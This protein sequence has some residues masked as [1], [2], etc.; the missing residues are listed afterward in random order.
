VQKLR[1]SEDVETLKEYEK[2]LTDMD[3]KNWQ[4]LHN[5]GYIS[6]LLWEL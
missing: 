4:Q 6:Y 2:T 3:Q 5:L 1:A